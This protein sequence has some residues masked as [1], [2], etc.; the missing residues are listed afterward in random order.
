MKGDPTAMASVY[1]RWMSSTDVMAHA[2]TVL[3]YPELYAVDYLL[4][5]ATECHKRDFTV[6]EE[7]LLHAAY[8]RMRAHADWMA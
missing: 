2:T 3:E 4:E 1:F 7:S 8:L 6:T 5:L